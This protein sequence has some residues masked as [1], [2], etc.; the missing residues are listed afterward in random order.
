VQEWLAKSE[1]ER[2][3]IKSGLS[4]KTIRNRPREMLKVGLD[5]IPGFEE[6][7]DQ[8]IS[9]GTATPCQHTA[10]G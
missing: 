10:L 2:D 4:G 1:L 7:E 9:W 6:D 3:L 5:R 8:S